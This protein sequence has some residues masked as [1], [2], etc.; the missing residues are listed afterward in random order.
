M[1]EYHE[2]L[3]NRWAD[4]ITR[5][6]DTFNV[7]RADGNLIPMIVPQPQQ[8]IIREGLLGTGVNYINS[9]HTLTTVT[10]KCRQAGFSVITAAESILVC[11]DFPRTKVFYC[12]PTGDQVEDWMLKLDQLVN[13]ANYYP[14]ELGGGPII[15][16][17]ILDNVYT[18]RI[19]E[20]YIVGFGANPASIRGKTGIMLVLD[21]MDWMIRFK[22][23]MRGTYNAAK[24]FVRQGGVIRALSTPRVKDSQFGEMCTDPRKHGV[25][26]HECPAITNWRQLNLT[27]PLFT[28]INNKR[29]EMKKLHI[30]T[31]N[32]VNAMLKRYKD[33]PMF[34][35]DEEKGTI[36]QKA[37]IP[38]PWITLEQL[39]KDCQADLE[40]F[41]QENL[42]VAVDEAYKVLNS[43]WIYCNINDE[44]E[45]EDR[46]DSLNPF[47]MSMDFAKRKDLTAITITERVNDTLWERYIF[48]TQ[49]D[50]D[51][52]IQEMWAI[53]LRFR[54]IAVPIDASPGSVGDVLADLLH[55]KFRQ[56]GIPTNIIK[57]I[58]FQ[59][60][61]KEQ[62]ALSFKEMV[63]N[64]RYKFLNQSAVHER[65]IRHCTRVEKEVLETA[66]RYSGKMHG[67]DDHFWSKALV[68]M[69][70]VN[71]QGKKPIS[72][73]KSSAKSYRRIRTTSGSGRKGG[74]HII[75]ELHAEQARLA[76]DET[77]PS[78]QS[79]R[80]KFFTNITKTDEIIDEL[81]HQKRLC[82]MCGKMV[83]Q[84]YA[85]TCKHPNCPYRDS[86]ER[87]CRRQNV[88]PDDVRERQTYYK[89]EK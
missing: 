44:G 3:L 58:P 50:Y 43:E 2:L 75:E 5:I 57:K 13:D 10:T 60:P 4:P 23:Q 47:Y 81:K 12:A 65:A 62:M 45:I 63:R 87:A 61:T 35:I 48:E 49:H 85:L 31:D 18:K 69:Y 53:F 29:R 42:C 33:K 52:Q 22:G 36:Y 28:D 56:E 83:N 14:E 67:R 25:V 88:S 40:Q 1:N 59:N 74:Q 89:K 9:G 20:A 51:S 41:M 82:V 34:V 73:V 11:N 16:K 21:E 17:A 76:K 19:N 79:P 54:P 64:N 72:K 6:Q 68:T 86:A 84:L 27:E 78:H 71:A 37:E 77:K 46:G 80:K 24:Y 70:D 66:V 8:P 38:Y 32:E 55:A 26:Y 30:L 7:E 15:K 39:S